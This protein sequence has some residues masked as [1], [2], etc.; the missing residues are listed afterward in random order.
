MFFVI[1]ILK[2]KEES[3]SKYAKTKAKKAWPKPC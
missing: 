1:H 3:E 2:M